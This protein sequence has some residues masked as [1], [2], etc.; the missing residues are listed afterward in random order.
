[1][2]KHDIKNQDYFICLIYY[3]MCAK[4]CMKSKRLFELS[5]TAFVVSTLSL[6]STLCVRLVFEF[7]FFGVF[8]MMNNFLLFLEMKVRVII[9]HVFYCHLLNFF[10]HCSYCPWGS[11][12][13]NTEV[14]C[15]CLL[16]W[17]MLVRAFR[18]THPSWVAVHS[19][20]HSLI[21]LDKAMV[22]MISLMSFQQ[23]EKA[24]RYDIEN[25]LLR[26]I[27]TQYATGEEWRNNSR[28]KDRAKAKI[29]PTCGCDWRW[30]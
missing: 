18:M 8:W 9:M 11:Q 12:G 1:M 17:T 19:M 13:K 6:Y 2:I 25:E 5:L 27:G 14:V 26:L 20:A 3:K 24:K 7:F 15:H 30:K 16:Q 28:K 22:N 23:Y 29:M 4:N 21:E 10:S